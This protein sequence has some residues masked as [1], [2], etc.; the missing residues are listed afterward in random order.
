MIFQKEFY[1]VRHGQTDYN[2][3]EEKRKEDHPDD[4]PL[5]ETGKN[6]AKSIR[7][8]EKK[9]YEF[10]P[11]LRGGMYR[12]AVTQA[13]LTPPGSFSLGY[14]VYRPSGLYVEDFV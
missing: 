2:I 6:Q 1:F 5:N 11:A 3:I 4:I 14:Y 12:L 10:V 9:D 8:C 13:S 7:G